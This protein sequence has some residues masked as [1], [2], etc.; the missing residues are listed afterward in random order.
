M[1]DRWS[2]LAALGRDV[3]RAGRYVGADR[4]L[5]SIIGLVGAHCSLTMAFDSMM[6]TLSERVGGTS[7]LYSAIL[8]ALGLGAISGTLGVSQLKTSPARGTVFAAT[9]V[10]SGLAM[11]VLGLA[12]TPAVV[13]LGALLAGLTQASYMA[14]SAAFIQEVVSDDFRG[15]VMSLYL[16]IAAG[17]MA[18][19]NLGF[20][21]L[22][23]VIDVRVLLVG[24]GLAWVVVFALSSVGLVEVRS[25]VRRGRFLSPIARPSTI[26]GTSPI[27]P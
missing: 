7:G 8:V 19:L 9:G 23:E 5:F 21:R 15:R 27:G 26:P 17:H 16:M 24:P 14:M 12:A 1:A 11:V 4:R 3:G 22:A 10:G 20:G 18:I 13:V 25:I 2:R 6:P